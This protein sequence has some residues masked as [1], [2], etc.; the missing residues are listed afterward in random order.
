[1]D[2]EESAKQFVAHPDLKLFKDNE[3]IVLLK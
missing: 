2:S 1:M 3:M